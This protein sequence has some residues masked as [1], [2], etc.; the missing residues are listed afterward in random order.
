MLPEL[1]STFI[2]NLTVGNVEFDSSSYDPKLF[3]Y[4]LDS[5]IPK[6][7]IKTISIDIS[8]VSLLWSDNDIISLIRIL[9]LNQT[10]CSRF[11]M[12]NGSKVS[13]RESEIG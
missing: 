12:T 3:L 2:S 6:N 1:W 4:N 9:R 11:V 7:A 5:V 8:S 10:N 13:L